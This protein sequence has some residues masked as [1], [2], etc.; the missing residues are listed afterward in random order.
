M[1][2]VLCFLSIF[3]LINDVNSQQRVEAPNDPCLEPVKYLPTIMSKDMQDWL[4]KH[5]FYERI[6]DK[7]SEQVLRRSTRDGRINYPLH[8]AP[9][10]T[11]LWDMLTNYGNDTQVLEDLTLKTRPN[12][13]PV[14]FHSYFVPVIYNNPGSRFKHHHGSK[15][16]YD[17]N[18]GELGV[19]QPFANLAKIVLYLG[20]FQG[21]EFRLDNGVKYQGNQGCK[22]KTLQ[23]MFSFT[24]V[25]G[26]G[27]LLDLFYVHE[28]LPVNSNTIKSEGDEFI[29]KRYTKFGLGVRIIYQK[30]TPVDVVV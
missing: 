30:Q 19:D 18:Y 5:F 23:K 8:D 17:S 16:Y 6:I 13:I 7:L 20:E 21:G 9:F 22:N 2:G 4:L 3:I 28:A 14:G 10:A 15:M 27:I 26:S 1:L 24:P 11:Q 12:W 29:H 25:A